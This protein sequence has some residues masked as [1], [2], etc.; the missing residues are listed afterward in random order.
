MGQALVDSGMRMGGQ[1]PAQGGVGYS[2]PAPSTPY[3]PAFSSQQGAG[4][5]SGFGGLANTIANSGVFE[6]GAGGLRAGA[7]SSNISPMPTMANDPISQFGDR[8]PK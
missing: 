6:G 7:G 4:T 8:T 5:T 3:Q 1:A 2:A